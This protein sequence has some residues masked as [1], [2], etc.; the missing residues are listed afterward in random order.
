MASFDIVSKVNLQEVDNAVNQ[1]NK[2]ITQRYDLKKSGSS[3]NFDKTNEITLVSEDDYKLKAVV[4]VLQSKLIKRKVPLKNINY[5]KPEES[6][7]QKVKVIAEIIQGIPIEKAREIVKIIKSTK[8]K[9]QVSIEGD[10][11]RVNGKKIDDLQ[12]IIQILKQKDLN[13]NLQFLNFRP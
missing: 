5:G 4:D 7:G 3:I 6:S 8:I 2:E 1:A 13:I 9:I 11:V 12:E 10:K